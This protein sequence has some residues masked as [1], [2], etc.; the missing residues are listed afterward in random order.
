[1]PPGAVIPGNLPRPGSQPPC[2][3]RT[4]SVSPGPWGPPDS[5]ILLPAPWTPAVPRPTGQAGPGEEMTLLDVLGVCVVGEWGCWPVCVLLLDSQEVSA[6]TLTVPRT[7]S[8]P[9]GY[10]SLDLPACPRPCPGLGALPDPVRASLLL[11]SPPVTRRSLAWV[12][13][14]LTTPS[15]RLG[16]TGPAGRG[17]EPADGRQGR[18]AS[19]G[20]GG[21][22]SGSRWAGVCLVPFACE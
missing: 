1:M 2:L 13:A 12:Q 14:P 6:L 7:R 3:L 4:G 8:F 17:Q 10:S 20:E 9:C 22:S 16:L 5:C 18:A 19:G 11:P 15:A 21:R